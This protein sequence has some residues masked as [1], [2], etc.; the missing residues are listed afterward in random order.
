MV[1]IWFSPLR[2]PRA[3]GDA[4]HDQAS[5][6]CFAK[7]PFKFLKILTQ[8]STSK[9]NRNNIHIFFTYVLMLKFN[10]TRRRKKSI[11]LLFLQI[12]PRR[13]FCKG[14]LPQPRTLTCRSPSLPAT[15]SLPLQL[16]T[17]AI[18]HPLCSLTPRR[19]LRSPSPS[20]P[21]SVAPLPPLL[22][23]SARS[24]G[25]WI[26]HGARVGGRGARAGRPR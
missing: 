25:I 6:G 21:T 15:F 5:S 9:R 17:A 2:I 26:R 18:S 11:I 12:S 1:K 4:C 13:H 10:S 14:T 23:L 16:P 7:K 20:L 24:G 19:H 3:K 8:W 22:L